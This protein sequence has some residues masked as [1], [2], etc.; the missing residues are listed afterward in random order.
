M[1]IVVSGYNQDFEIVEETYI[2]ENDQVIT[3]PVRIKIDDNTYMMIEI[4]KQEENDT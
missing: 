4:P 3:R 2:I 1:K